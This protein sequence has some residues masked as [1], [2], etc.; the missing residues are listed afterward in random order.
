MTQ[1]S[2]EDVLRLARLSKLQLTDNEIDALASD[3]TAILGY[4]EQLDELDTEGVE[5]TYQV[6]GLTNVWRADEVE[7]GDVSRDELLSLAPESTDNQI[8]VQKVL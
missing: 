4:V 7:V 3:I 8:K 1:I 6:T 2:R 5:P